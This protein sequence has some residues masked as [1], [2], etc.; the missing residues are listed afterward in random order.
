M[1]KNNETISVMK[2]IA[3]MMIVMVHCLC[4]PELFRFMSFFHLPI[5][6]FSTGYFFKESYLLNPFDFA[7]RKFKGLYITFVKWQFTFIILHNVFTYLHINASYYGINEVVRRIFAVLKFV[8]AELLLMPFWFLLSA[9]VC[10]WVYFIIRYIVSFVNEKYKKSVMLFFMVVS[11]FIGLILKKVGF[12][13][14]Y[15]IESSFILILILYFGEMFRKYERQIPI[16]IYLASVCLL[17]LCVLV[18]FKKTISIIS[19]YFWDYWQFYL[20]AVAGIY[21]VYYVTVKMLAYRWLKRIFVIMG[22]E[23][24]YILGLHLLSFK[25]VDGIKILIYND[26]TIDNLS[27]F[28]CVAA[29]HNVAFW[30]FYTIVGVSVPLIIKKALDK[31]TV[32]IVKRIKKVDVY[33]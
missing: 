10:V 2:G 12:E 25:I 7:K 3:I 20:G 4:P 6:Y 33:G 31:L 26:L 28:T 15:Y 1:K 13:S 11:F 9:F 27:D 30:L 5:F 22:N 16:N 24:I 21:F 19:G 14:I 32:I 29:H 8:Q 23:S 17:C 18:Y